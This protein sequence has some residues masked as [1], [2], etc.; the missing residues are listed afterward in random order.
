MFGKSAD[1]GTR[2]GTTVRTP[3]ADENQR[4]RI[5]PER[6]GGGGSG[7]KL[8]V[9]PNI[10]LKGA[11]IEDC[12]TLFV[13]GQVE[14]SM[15]SR[16]IQIAEPGVFLGA[17]AVDEAEIHGRFEG[18]LTVRERLVIHKTGRVRGTIR[19]GRLDIEE[20]GEI[21]GDVAAVQGRDETAD[22]RVPIAVRRTRD[23]PAKRSVTQSPDDTAPSAAPD[24]PAAD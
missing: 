21:A 9:G 18:D 20:G 10:R 22:R 11:S 17:A 24:A 6:P 7:G 16:L 13:E 8:T 5:L 3:P 15:D 12:D 23:Q 2:A 19:Y 14:A 4:A 1:R